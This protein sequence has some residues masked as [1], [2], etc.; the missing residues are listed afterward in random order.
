MMKKIVEQE[1]ELDD[2]VSKNKS[3]AMRRK[4][5]YFKKTGAVTVKKDKTDS[6]SKRLA[7]SRVEKEDLTSVFK[8][9]AKGVDVHDEG[10]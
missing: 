6:E 2:I 4:N 5:N 1:I 10:F 8:M 7:K 9:F 3:R